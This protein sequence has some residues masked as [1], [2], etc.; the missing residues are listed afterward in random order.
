VGEWNSS[1]LLVDGNHVEHWLNGVK[2]LSYERASAD[3]KTR[4]AESK[5]KDI[6]G[7]GENAKGHLLLQDHDNEVYYRNMKLRVI[8]KK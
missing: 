5:Y 7:F 3:M 1:R 4:I 6:K 8:K 2:V